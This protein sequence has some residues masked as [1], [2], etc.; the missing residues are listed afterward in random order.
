[1]AI[2][3]P[4]RTAEHQWNIN[5]KTR[6]KVASY[7]QTVPMQMYQGAERTVPISFAQIVQHSSGRAS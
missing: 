7:L 5:R 4:L 6:K 2:I 3:Y 1:M